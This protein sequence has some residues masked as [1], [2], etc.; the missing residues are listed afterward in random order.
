L[1]FWQVRSR[2]CFSRHSLLHLRRRQIG[3][4]VVPGLE[5]TQTPKGESNTFRVDVA[6][7]TAPLHPGSFAGNI[8][9]RTDDAAFP[10]LTVPVSGEIR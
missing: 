7:S 10:E 5:F 2:E 9:V 4:A 6:L 3:R 8:R 1:V